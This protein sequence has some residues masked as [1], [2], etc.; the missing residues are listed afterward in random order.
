MHLFYL[1]PSWCDLLC[2]SK[3]FRCCR[4]FGGLGLL[5][6]VTVCIFPALMTFL[7]MLTSCSSWCD[8]LCFFMVLSL[9]P[10]FLVDLASRI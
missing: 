9:L 6:L 5:D 3:I 4:R 2:S 8:L 1:L 10:L 7:P